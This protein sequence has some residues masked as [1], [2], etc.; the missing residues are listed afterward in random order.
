MMHPFAGQAAIAAETPPGKRSAIRIFE[1]F[2]MLTMPLISVIW[3]FT[4]EVGLA[5]FGTVLSVPVATARA[6]S[7]KVLDR[8]PP[9]EVAA[10]GILLLVGSGAGTERTG[11]PLLAFAYA[12]AGSPPNV[13][14][15]PALIA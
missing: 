8:F 7:V 12:D 10:A 5:N 9:K 2:C 6:E 15:S 13:A 4:R 1:R 14:A 11:E 3:E